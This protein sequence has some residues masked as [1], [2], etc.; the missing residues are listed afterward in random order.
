MVLRSPY[1]IRPV[2][3]ELCG[4]IREA[5]DHTAVILKP[6]PTVFALGDLDKFPMLLLKRCPGD[7][8]DVAEKLP[9]R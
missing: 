2:L 6:A 9:T 5:N 3:R 4:H 1:S 8:L 7:A